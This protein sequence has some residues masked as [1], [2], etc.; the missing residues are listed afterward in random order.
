MKAMERTV[1]IKSLFKVVIPLIYCLT[2]FREF[3]TMKPVNRPKPIKNFIL[4]RFILTMGN[5]KRAGIR[6]FMGR[7]NHLSS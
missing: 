1:E 3:R 2:A 4:S 7:K 5:L 6:L